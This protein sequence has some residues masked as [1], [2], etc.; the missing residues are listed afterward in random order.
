MARLTILGAGT[1]TPTPSRYGTSYV[2]EIGGEQIMVDC[3]PATTHK[4][5]KA[6]LWPTNIDYL[7]FTHHHFDHDVDYPCFLLT[8]WDQSIGKENVLQVFGPTLTEQLTH[9]ILDENEGA[10]SHDWK[11]RV[12]HPASQ[13]VYMNRGGTPPRMPPEV[14]AKDITSGKIFSGPSWEVSLERMPSTSSRTSTR[15]PT[16]STATRAAWSSPGIPS[17]A[18]PS[19]NWP[20]ERMSL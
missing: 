3:G 20:K 10:F 9:R 7:F 6:G 1:P 18:T 4:L 11:A 19:R 2:L 17:L 12:N 15:S 13:L 8:R 16:A 5:V 14:S